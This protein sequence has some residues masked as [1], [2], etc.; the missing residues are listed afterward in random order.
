MIGLRFIRLFRRRRMAGEAQFAE[1]AVQRA[2]MTGIALCS[3]KLTVKFTDRDV[4]IVAVII[5]NPFEFLL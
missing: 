2:G 4:R 3:A 5:P 1:D